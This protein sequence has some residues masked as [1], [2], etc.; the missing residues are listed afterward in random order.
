[1]EDKEL[2]VLGMIVFTLSFMGI[3]YVMGKHL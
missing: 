2:K 1:M 3:I